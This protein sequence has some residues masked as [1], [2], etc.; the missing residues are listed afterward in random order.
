[1]LVQLHII[2]RFWFCTSLNYLPVEERLCAHAVR[3]NIIIEVQI[4]SITMA[5][6][7]LQSTREHILL[8]KVI[9]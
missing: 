8:S 7:D 1:M 2:L 4:V 6:I 3:P 5:W 9:N